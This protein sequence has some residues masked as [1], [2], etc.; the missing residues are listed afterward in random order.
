M[1]GF[2]GQKR[3]AYIWIREEELVRICNS[4]TGFLSTSRANRITI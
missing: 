1:G 3:L 4:S 2:S